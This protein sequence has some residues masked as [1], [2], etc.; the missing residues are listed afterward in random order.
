VEEG[1]SE[2]SKATADWKKG[3]REGGTPPRRGGIRKEGQSTIGKDNVSDRLEKRRKTCLKRQQAGYT[4]VIF[5]LGKK[6][7]QQTF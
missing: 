3:K 7:R 1:K 6:S 2:K 5:K 4:R